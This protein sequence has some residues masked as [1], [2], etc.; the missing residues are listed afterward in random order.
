[1]EEKGKEKGRREKD[2][3]KGKGRR[4][5]RREREKEKDKGKGER[6]GEEASGGGETREFFSHLG[7][8]GLLKVEKEEKECLTENIH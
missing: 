5:R 1:M 7:D 4:G 8:L 3:G 2:K 6:R